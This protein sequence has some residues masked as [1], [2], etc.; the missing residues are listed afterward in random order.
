[1]EKSLLDE[2][3]SNTNEWTPEP[4]YHDLYN[5]LFYKD[6]IF[7]TELQNGELVNVVTYI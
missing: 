7:S 1:M 6:V 5:D 3:S 2:Q 4:F